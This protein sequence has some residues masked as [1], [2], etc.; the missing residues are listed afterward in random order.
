MPCEIPKGER[1]PVALSV[2]FGSCVEV[3]VSGIPYRGLND[4]K[5][6]MKSMVLFSLFILFQ[7]FSLEAG[8]SYAV[9][10]PAVG[11]LPAAI[12]D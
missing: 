1:T 8:V 12:G 11:W 3:I 9:D 2:D 6:M 10:T 7:A 5:T 4:R